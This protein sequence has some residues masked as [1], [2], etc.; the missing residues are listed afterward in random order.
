M[1][2]LPNYNFVDN[3]FIN[4]HKL[5]QGM[6]NHPEPPDSRRGGP[7]GRFC[8]S[9]QEIGKEKGKG[10]KTKERDGGRGKGGEGKAG[11]AA[12]DSWKAIVAMDANGVRDRV[13]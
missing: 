4:R 10:K 2:W 9:K 7:L 5:V 1:T 12:K 11:E 6:L 8:H 3:V 13:N